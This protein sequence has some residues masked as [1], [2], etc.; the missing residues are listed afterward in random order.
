LE[1]VQRLSSKIYNIHPTIAAVSS[2]GGVFFD[3]RFGICYIFE[4]DRSINWKW[5]IFGV[6]PLLHSVSDMSLNRKWACIEKV[7]LCTAVSMENQHPQVLKYILQRAAQRNIHISIDEMVNGL[8]SSLTE[9]GA[10][11]FLRS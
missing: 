6:V 2:S 8:N 11:P 3:N 4:L 10:E 7:T 5:A 1:L 9:H